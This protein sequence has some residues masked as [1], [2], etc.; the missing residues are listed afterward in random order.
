M[1]LKTFHHRTAG[2][3]FIMPNGQSLSFAGG[4][5]TTSDPAVITELEKI[6]NMP[7]SQV[8]TVS[9]VTGMEEAAV[10]AEIEK[11][12]TASFDAAHNI[13]G[14]AETVRIPVQPDLRPV[15]SQPRPAPSPQDSVE[16]ARAALAANAAASNS[17]KK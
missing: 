7:S 10:R 5:I 1:V 13:T 6:A 15:L 8:Y 9:P 11:S 16:K 12:A 17:A 4:K 14:H 2:A 3:C